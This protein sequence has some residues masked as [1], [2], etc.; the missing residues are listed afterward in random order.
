MDGKVDTADYNPAAKTADM[1]QAVGKDANGLLW[2][3]P[4]PNVINS[5][6]TTT[7]TGVLMGVGGAVGVKSVDATPTSDSDNLITSGAVYNAL[8]SAKPKVGTIALS[9]T[10]S[11][12]GPYSKTVTVTGATVTANSKVDLQPAATA[13]NNLISAGVTALWVENNSGTLTAYALGAAPS[14]GGTV[15]CTVTEVRT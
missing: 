10:W 15:Q 13:L 4:S 11:G 12:S 2:T 8:S 6:T 9:G 14:A 5:G 3:E 1:T 7:L